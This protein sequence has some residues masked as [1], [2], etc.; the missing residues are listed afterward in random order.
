MNDDLHQTHPAAKRARPNESIL[1]AANTARFDAL[2][3]DMLR[4]IVSLLATANECA[5]LR[6]CRLLRAHGDAPEAQLARVRKAYAEAL[7]ATLGALQFEQDRVMLYGPTSVARDTA[8]RHVADVLQRVV[9]VCEHEAS[10]STACCS[11]VLRIG[12]FARLRSAVR[13]RFL[14]FRMQRILYTFCDFAPKNFQR[15]LHWGWTPNGV[16]LMKRV[17]FMHQV[18]SAWTPVVDQSEHMKDVVRS[19]HD[20]FVAA[21]PPRRSLE[22]RINGFVKAMD[23]HVREHGCEPH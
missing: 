7:G 19:A 13:V 10:T 15:A 11:P 18:P 12:P 21:Y 16:A 6:T 1:S 5:L 20:E 9:Y 2:P 3:R 14:A 17:A 8:N 22:G 4:C 23:A